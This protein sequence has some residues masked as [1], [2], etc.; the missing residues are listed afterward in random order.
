MLMG[1]F[2]DCC[3]AR[4]YGRTKNSLYFLN[5]Y[6]RQNVHSRALIRRHSLD[7]PCPIR[8][9]RSW[10]HGVSKALVE[11]CGDVPVSPVTQ[12]YWIKQFGGHLEFEEKK[13]KN[14]EC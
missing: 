6:F 13:I 14:L 11:F 2:D 3:G 4:D 5:R 7:F 12:K 1:R 9:D 10:P 8:A